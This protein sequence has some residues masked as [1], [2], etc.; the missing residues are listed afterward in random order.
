MQGIVVDAREALVNKI[1]KISDPTAFFY[2]S[3][4]NKQ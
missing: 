3:G 4:E 1:N 2:S